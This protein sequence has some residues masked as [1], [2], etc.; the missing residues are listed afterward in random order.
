MHKEQTKLIELMILTPS[1][2]TQFTHNTH[3]YLE[4]CQP[5]ALIKRAFHLNPHNTD[6][7]KLIYKYHTKVCT[8][9]CTHVLPKRFWLRIW[10]SAGF[11]AL[12]SARKLFSATQTQWSIKRAA[13]LGYSRYLHPAA[14]FCLYRRIKQN[15]HPFSPIRIPLSGSFISSQLAGTG[16][17]TFSHC[18]PVMFVSVWCICFS[19][20]P[21]TKILLTLRRRR[22]GQYL[23]QLV[24]VFATFFPNPTLWQTFLS[25]PPICPIT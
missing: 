16:N 8:M 13:S 15:C 11:T 3:P 7:L 5:L 6:L 9:V 2:S 22:A 4:F 23:F 17:K 24:R 12:S 10:T 21:G 25:P 18:C 19:S 14:V 1:Q 20:Q